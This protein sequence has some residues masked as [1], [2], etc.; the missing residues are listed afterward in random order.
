[1]STHNGMGVDARHVPTSTGTP[2]TDGTDG[3]LGELG[4]E[5]GG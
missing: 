1:M 5:E 4:H 3:D 2:T